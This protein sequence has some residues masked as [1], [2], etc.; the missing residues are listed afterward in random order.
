MLEVSAPDGPIT[1][2]QPLLHWVV[3]G[4][5]AVSRQAVTALAEQLRLPLFTD[6]AT[7]WTHCLYLTIEHLELREQ[8]FG[9]ISS[10]HVDFIK[11]SVGYRRRMGGGRHQPLA[12]AVG[13]KG[14]ETPTIIDATAGLGRDAFV[15][16]C[17]GCTVTL[18]ERSPLVAALLADG[19][20]R[21]ERDPEI[22]AMV[23]ERLQLLTIDSQGY[24]KNLPETKRPEVVYL[25]PMYPHRQKSAL[26]KKEMRLLRQM[27]GNDQDS[28]AL[29]AAAL[30]ATQKRVVVKRPRLAP[31]LE[32]PRPSFEI[33]AANT[34]FD[35][36][37]IHS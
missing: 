14:D 2:S 36:Y 32:G 24:L 37:R 7:T 9:S 34:R 15:L 30:A 35:V 3:G 1:A 10:F 8:S 11:G 26:V 33:T 23:R 27:V 12:R 18:L 5:A 25:D 31:P 28:P 21:A 19:L 13:I 6:P 16:A 20:A 29:L 22:G 17:L 4:E